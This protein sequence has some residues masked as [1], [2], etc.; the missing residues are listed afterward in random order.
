M[1]HKLLV[2]VDG[3]KT[4]RK[5]ALYAAHACA[6]S[7]SSFPEIV[8]FHVFV[9][10]PPFVEGADPV[11]ADEL[12][13]RME[14]QRTEAA[15]KMLADIKKTIICEG[16]KPKLVTTELAERQGDVMKQI[17]R[18]AA[19]HHC[20]TIVIGRHSRSLLGEFLAESV[21]EHILRTPSGYTIWLVA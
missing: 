10:I 8:V 16:V 12:A 2:A 9:P 3:G 18:A 15:E 1:K 5:T 4:S 21:A 7:E 13:E 17:V 11:A 19:A 20:D 14:R 6:G